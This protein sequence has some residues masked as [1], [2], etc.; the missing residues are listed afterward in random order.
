MNLAQIPRQ[1][2]VVIAELGKHILGRDEIGIIV[3]HALQ[4]AY[5]ADRAQGGAA[6]LS[7]PFGDRVRS[8]EDLISVL[9]E[10]EVIVT[11]MWTGHVP[12]KVLGFQIERK[13]V[14]E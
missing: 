8:R 7:N 13:H 5:V 2:L 10:E 6:D 14:G 3:Q 11:E 4:A 12:M 1:L 9:V